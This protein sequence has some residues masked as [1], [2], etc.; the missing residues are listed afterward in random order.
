MDKIFALLGC[1]ATLI[2]SEFPTFRDNL[3]VSSSRIKQSQTIR[4]IFVFAEN[5]VG[6]ELTPTRPGPIIIPN[7]TV[8]KAIGYFLL[9]QAMPVRFVILITM[10][11]SRY[12]VSYI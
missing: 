12:L 2:R 8:T 11:G 3:P 10:K 4:Y 1:C 6:E 9:K 5:G 7:C